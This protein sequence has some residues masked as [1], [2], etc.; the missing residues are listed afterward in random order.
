MSTIDIVFCPDYQIEHILMHC[1]A[2]TS[3][4]QQVGSEDCIS[5]D[6]EQAETHCIGSRVYREAFLWASTVLVYPAELQARRHC[7]L[8]VRGLCT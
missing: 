3:F 6:V 7:C 1:Q 4:V 2:M 5:L 8:E